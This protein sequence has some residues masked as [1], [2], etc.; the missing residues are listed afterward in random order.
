MIR[1][2]ARDDGDEQI[3]KGDSVEEVLSIQQVAECLCVSIRQLQNLRKDESFP[4]P[5]RVGKVK[6]VYRTK[7]INQFIQS[8][9]LV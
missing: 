5:V 7:D 4:H 8:G 2:G 1:N 9:G 6:V 3:L